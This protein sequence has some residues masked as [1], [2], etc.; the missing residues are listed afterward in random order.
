MLVRNLGATGEP[1]DMLVR[2]TGCGSMHGDPAELAV[3]RG[4][5]DYDLQPYVPRRVR[6]AADRRLT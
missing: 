1:E 4:Q 3:P 5:A 2:M 6:Q